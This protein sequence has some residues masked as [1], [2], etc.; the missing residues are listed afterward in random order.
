VDHFA[1][2]TIQAARV[3]ARQRK[4]A[5]YDRQLFGVVLVRHL[6]ADDGGRGVLAG[7]VTWSDRLIDPTDTQTVS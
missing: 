2:D 5:R 7:S 3:A 4:T 1:A 6:P